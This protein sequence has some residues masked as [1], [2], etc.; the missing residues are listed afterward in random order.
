MV[1]DI[2]LYIVHDIVLQEY[3]RISAVLYGVDHR[4]LSI[5]HRRSI[6]ALGYNIQYKYKY[7]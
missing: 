7:L 1:H 6:P 5:Q 4:P 3:F 2:V